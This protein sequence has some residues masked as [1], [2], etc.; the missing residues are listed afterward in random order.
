MVADQ[1]VIYIVLGA[2]NYLRESIFSAKSLKRNCPDIPIT[3]FTDR[4]DVNATCFDQIILID[5]DVNPFKNKVKYLCE[6][7]YKKTLFLDSDTQVRKPLYELFE[8]LDKVDLALTSYPSIDRSYIPS[9]LISYEQPNLYN[10]GVILY[11]NSSPTQHFLNRWLDVVM[12]QDESTMWAGHFCDQYYF[13]NLIEQN[14][15]EEFEVK[16]SKLPNKVYNV[17]P[18]M[19]LPMLKTGEMKDAKILH[20]HD[21]H[22]TLVERQLNRLYKRF[23][24]KSA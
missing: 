19:I 20:C 7:P 15:H 5:N 16:L 14:L 3:L 13:N 10:T 12:Q 21:L 2:L 22:K 1:G 4:T 11:R 17:R 23:V 18:P 8:M 9:K 6:S 24:R